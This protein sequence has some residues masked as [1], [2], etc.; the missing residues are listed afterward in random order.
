MTN[1]YLKVVR[2]GEKSAAAF[3]P[4]DDTDEYATRA[5]ITQARQR[6]AA[7]GTAAKPSRVVAWRGD[8]SPVPPPSMEKPT[9]RRAD[10]FRTVCGFT[11]D[12]VTQVP[13]KVLS[14]EAIMRQR[15]SADAKAS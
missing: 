6:A 7:L 14:Q 4:F 13:A 3:F 11:V 15:A 2:Y 1:N 5:V 10:G 8:C 9:A 12:G